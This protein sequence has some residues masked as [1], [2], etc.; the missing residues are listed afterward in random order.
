MP[1]G[2]LANVFALPPL[3]FRFQYNPDLLQERKRYKYQQAN[4]FG[5]WTFDQTS[6]ASG[7]L[8]VMKG[9]WRT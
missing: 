5:R 1:R 3:I 2:L 6:A 8:D 7:A 9:L 4:S